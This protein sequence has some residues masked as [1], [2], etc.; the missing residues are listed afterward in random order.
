VKPGA[1][2]HL[3]R[4]IDRARPRRKHF[5]DPVWRELERG[6]GHGQL[7]HVLAAPA[8]KVGDEHVAPVQMQLGLVQDD[9][10]VP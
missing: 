5:A 6:G 10:P 2:G 3:V 4:A 9:P 8:G 7:R 1:S